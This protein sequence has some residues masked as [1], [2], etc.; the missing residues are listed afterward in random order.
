MSSGSQKP[1]FRQRGLASGRSWYCSGD[2]LV[3]LSRVKRRGEGAP[4]ELDHFSARRSTGQ[5]RKQR[6]DA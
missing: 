3:V 1:S 6:R 4:S 5:R 2:A